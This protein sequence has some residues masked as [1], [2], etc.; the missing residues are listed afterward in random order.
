MI[1]IQFIVP[2]RSDSSAQGILP[3][4]KPVIEGARKTKSLRIIIMLSRYL[5]R[6]NRLQLEES[7]IPRKSH[8]EESRLEFQRFLYW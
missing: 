7:Y 5:C 3:L 4:V 1:A 8:E 6:Q 2:L